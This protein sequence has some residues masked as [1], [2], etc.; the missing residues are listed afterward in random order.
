MSLFWPAVVDLRLSKDE[1][2]MSLR[3][4]FAIT[5]QITALLTAIERVRVHRIRVPLLEVWIGRM[6]QRALLP[7]VCYTIGRREL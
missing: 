4:H 7:E 3:P 2:S 5:N 6:S 1:I